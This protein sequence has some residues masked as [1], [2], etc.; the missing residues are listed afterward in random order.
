MPEIKLFAVNMPESVDEPLL[1]TLHS[2]YIGQGPKVEE[3]ETL[4]RDYFKVNA[5]TVNSGT[6]AITLALRLANVGRGDEVITTPMTCSATNLPILSLGGIPVFADVDPE[7]GLI[8]PES[9]ASLITPKTKAIL[10]VDWGGTPGPSVSLSLIAKKHKLKLIIDSAHA[11]GAPH[12]IKPLADFVCFSLQAIKHITTVDGGVL[13]CKN[14]GDA[15][16]GRALRWFGINRELGSLDSRINEDIF[17]W[18]YKFHMNDVAATIGIEQMKDLRVILTTHQLTA[19]FYDQKISSY[20]GKPPKG[21]GAYWLYTLRLPTTKARDEF[22]TFMAARQIMVSQ[23]HRRND[24]YKVFKPYARNLP[25][26]SKFSSTM[27]CIPIHAKLTADEV[28]LIITSCNEFV[29]TQT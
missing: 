29:E 21:I 20:Y 22:K 10:A 17:E 27:V 2:G 5:L 25:G 12:T 19:H 26:V 3:F 4:L 1:K 16:R 15:A 8:D 24:E 9:V 28:Q 6:S 7:T 18:G 13:L 14:I 23:V 11:F